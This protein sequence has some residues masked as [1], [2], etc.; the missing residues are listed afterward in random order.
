GAGI[1]IR[2]GKDVEAVD[3]TATFLEAV[4]RP[5]G[6]APQQMSVRDGFRFFG[7]ALHFPH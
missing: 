4:D 2:D 3:L 7:D 5:A 1:R 6:P